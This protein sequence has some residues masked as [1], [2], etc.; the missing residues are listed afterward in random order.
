MRQLAQQIVRYI[1]RLLV[2]SRF[3]NTLRVYL[4]LDERDKPPSVVTSFTERRVLI[5]APHIDDEVIGCGGVIQLHA[6]AGAKV[7]VAYMTDGRKGN[8]DLYCQ[9]LSARALREAEDAVVRTRKAEAYEAARVLEIKDLA[10]LDEPD[11]SLDTTADARA[12]LR[13][14]LADVAPDLIYLPSL[15]DTHNDHWATNRLLHAALKELQPS[16]YEMPTIRGYEV[17]SPGYVNRIAD[18]TAVQERKFEAMA[19]FE[20]Q[21]EGT[22]FLRTAQALNVYRSVHQGYG[23]GSAE[24]FLELTP[25]AFLALMDA[26][27]RTP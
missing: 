18:I 23:R 7:S 12:K 15:M 21:I 1:Y 20:S 19:R 10:F 11:G 4:L 13:Q 25:E 6:Q 24:A 3:K 14:I 8:R 16:G 2:P 27:E 9:G 26:L 22:D 17:W 5:L